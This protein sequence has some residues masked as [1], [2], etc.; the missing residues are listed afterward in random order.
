MGM[1]T[2]ELYFKPKLRVINDD[3][4]QQIHM[5]TLDVLE[6][7]GVKMTHKRGV[8]ILEGGGAKVEG[9]RVRIPSWMVED[10]IRKAPHRLV[11]GKRTGERAL[12]VEADKSYFGPSLDCMDYMDPATHER[13]RFTTEHT[14]EMAALCDGLPSFEWCMTIGMADD[15]PA[16]IADRAVA[17]NVMEYCEKPL[18]FCCKD[19]NSV[20]DIHEMALLLCGGKENFEKAPFVVHYSEPI[21]PLVYY[22]PAVDKIL[23]SVE[24]GIPLINFPCTSGGGSGPITFA[25]T[26]VQSS[27]ESLSGLVL[28]QLVKP[29]AQFVYGAFT[30]IIDMKTTIFSYGANEFSLMTA[31]LAQM[32]QYYR[33][34]FFGTAG[35]TDAKFCDAQA[36]AEVAFQCFSAAAVGSGLVHDCSTWMDHGVM[37]SPEF[38]VL[39]SEIVDSVKHYMRGIPVNEE[40][41]ALDVM[42]KVGPGGH[43]LQQKHTMDHFRDIKYSE[44][45]E[46]EVLG[47]WESS[48]SKKFE[49]R[50]QE[51]TLEKMKHRPKPLSEDVVKELDRMQASW[52]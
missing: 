52:K 49:Q 23:Y 26:M 7:I 48:G 31:G 2:D 29:G 18:V 6:H 16:D 14:K 1:N 33:L 32:A 34:P 20:K 12:V 13:I 36:G 50:L 17:R 51:V 9:D 15:V 40:T 30:S 47:K 3:Q 44:I 11:L 24:N 45:F 42:K 39:A 28:A 4:I 22:D 8:E 37:V 46:R 5:A 38:M 10:A 43:Y 41:L 25:G 27:A 21:S 19:T 35:A